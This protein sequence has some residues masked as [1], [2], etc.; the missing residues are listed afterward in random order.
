MSSES[1]RL[2][3]KIKIDIQRR[4]KHGNYD[5]GYSRDGA[6]VR[7]FAPHKKGSAKL[8]QWEAD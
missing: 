6:R 8:A 1:D 5:G 2:R 7:A 3:R 4:R